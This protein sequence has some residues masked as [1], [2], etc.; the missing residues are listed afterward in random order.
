MTSACSMYSGFKPF[1]RIILISV[2]L[3]AFSSFLFFAKAD[4]G[5]LSAGL[6][7]LDTWDASCGQIA[8]DTDNWEAGKHWSDAMA[9]H[10]QTYTNLNGLIA[11]WATDNYRYTW[12]DADNHL[13]AFD[14]SMIIT[15]G[16]VYTANGTHRW[17]MLMQ[18]ETHDDSCLLCP[19]MSFPGHDLH[20]QMFL[21]ETASDIEILHVFS[22]HSMEY[23]MNMIP[24]TWQYKAA[25]NNYRSAFAG[26]HQINGMH[27]VSH[28]ENGV[29]TPMRD[30][31]SNGWSNSVA[32]QWVFQLS[33]NRGDHPDDC[34]ISLACS[35]TSTH[36]WNVI[37][38]EQYDN[39]SNYPDI[40]DPDFCVIIWQ[41]GCDPDSAPALP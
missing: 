22:C 17:A 10:C 39:R 35:D 13:E 36:A 25:E 15:H 14:I 1:I 37:N 4:D 20:D 5:Y 33:R 28:T 3:F 31:G 21:G 9:A 6:F 19:G 12:G 27:G 8:H 7:V 24:N 32:H 29:N 40:A 18:R 23:Y 34:A 16:G 41:S 2:I 30:L 11:S 38:Y 26:I